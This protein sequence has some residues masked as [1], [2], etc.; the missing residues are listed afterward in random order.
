MLTCRN[1]WVKARWGD[2]LLASHH[3]LCQGSAQPVQFSKSQS[4]VP[5]NGRRT[6]REYTPGAAR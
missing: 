1:L 5:H 2:A 6:A 3:Y 4:L